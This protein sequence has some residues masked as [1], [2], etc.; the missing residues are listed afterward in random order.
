MKFKTPS[1]TLQSVRLKTTSAVTLLVLTKGAHMSETIAEFS[2]IGVMPGM[3]AG[4]PTLEEEVANMQDIPEKL[5]RESAERKHALS[6]K[7]KRLL[8]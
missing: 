1:F 7:K 4:I 2:K 6:F 8:S 5:T 3:M